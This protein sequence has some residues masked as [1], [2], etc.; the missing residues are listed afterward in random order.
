MQCCYLLNNKNMSTELKEGDLVILKSGGPTM[1]IKEIKEEVASC[2]WFNKD[3]VTEH[4][5]DYKISTLIK[6]K[7]ESPI[8]IP[9]DDKNKY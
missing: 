2:I 6:Y 8:F 7:Y 1:T 4:K 3:R 9:K 5:G